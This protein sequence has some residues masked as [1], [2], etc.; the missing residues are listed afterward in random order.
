M[1]VVF[2]CCGL[3]KIFIRIFL[4]LVVDGC[5]VNGVGVGISIVIYSMKSKIV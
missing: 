5:N 2:V 3:S 4:E 1:I